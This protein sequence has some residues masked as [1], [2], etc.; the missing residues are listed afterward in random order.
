MDDTIERGAKLG[1]GL[2]IGWIGVS[3]SLGLIALTV[4]YLAKNR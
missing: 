3:I 1:A 4:A 2:A